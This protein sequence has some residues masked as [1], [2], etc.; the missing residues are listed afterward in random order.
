ML[1]R[2]S[3]KHID[4]NQLASSIVDEATAEIIRNSPEKNPAAVML[5]RIGGLKGGR[6]RA[7]SLSARKRAEIAKQA[8]LARWGRKN[9]GK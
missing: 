2:S 6:A 1:K 8:A 5:G 7:Q 4:I 9:D 3:K